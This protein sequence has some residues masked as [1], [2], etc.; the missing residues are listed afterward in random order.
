MGYNYIH[1]ESYPTLSRVICFVKLDWQKVVYI[2]LCVHYYGKWIIVQNWHL[3]LENVF[4]FSL[5]GIDFKCMAGEFDNV[6][7]TIN[8]KWVMTNNLLDSHISIG[9]I[10]YQF[11]PVFFFFSLLLLQKCDYMDLMVLILIIR[12]VVF[13]FSV[14]SVLSVLLEFIPRS[15]T[16]NNNK[17][18]T[19][20]WVDSCGQAILRSFNV[21]LI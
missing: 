16:L 3:A 15:T 13:F 9:S 11:S 6:Y 4:R 19:Y 2:Y 12:F 8:S 10:L 21:L 7:R 20:K 1:F 18:K 17:F 14:L 5:S